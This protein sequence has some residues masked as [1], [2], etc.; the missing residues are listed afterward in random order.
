MFIRIIIC[1]VLFAIMDGVWFTF[2]MND[3]AISKIA[4]IL[5]LEENL[6]SVRFFEAFMAYALMV[7]SAVFFLD[8]KTS[9]SKNYFESFMWGALLGICIFGVFD[10]TNGALMKTYPLSFIIVDTLWG[11][12]MYGIAAISMKKLSS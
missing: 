4:P 7:I 2:F 12:F 10:F 8:S 1:T 3:F 11:G 6:L 9:I 5:N